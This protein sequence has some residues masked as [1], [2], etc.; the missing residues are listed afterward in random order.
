[1]LRVAMSVVLPGITV[2]CAQIEAT[3][4]CSQGS[5]T[6]DAALAEVALQRLVLESQSSL[7]PQLVRYRSAGDFRSQNP[8]CCFLTKPTDYRGGLIQLPIDDS[9][10]GPSGGG[11]ELA[12]RYRRMKEGDAPYAIRYVTI[13]PCPSDM[14]EST[15]VMT[16][17]QYE[18]SRSWQWTWRIK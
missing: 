7:Y 17:E 14:E 4:T 18:A 12:F 1:M 2:S 10:D 8:D 3:G 5:E 13:G 9:A 11:M 15:R 16:A 6:S